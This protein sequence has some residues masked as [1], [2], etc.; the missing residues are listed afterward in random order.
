MPPVTLQVPRRGV[1][2]ALSH[3][4]RAIGVPL[5][6]VITPRSVCDITV[7]TAGMNFNIRLK[8]LWSDEASSRPV[9]YGGIKRLNVR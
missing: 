4:P 7:M 3:L 1:L 2:A 6:R 8:D 9:F 5:C